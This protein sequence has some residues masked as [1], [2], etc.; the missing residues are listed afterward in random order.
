MQDFIS[1]MNMNIFYRALDAEVF[2]I[3][4]LIMRILKVEKENI[5]S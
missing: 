2:S 3:D 1:L 4:L 5:Y